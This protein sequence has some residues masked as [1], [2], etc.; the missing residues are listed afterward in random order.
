MKIPVSDFFQF[1][2][3]FLVFCETPD[4]PAATAGMSH[5]QIL[6]TP[7]ISVGRCCLVKC[8][9]PLL[10]VILPSRVSDSPRAGCEYRRKEA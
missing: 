7:P 5:R 4:Q 10:F 1:P 2:H 8:I 9:P 3:V 6:R